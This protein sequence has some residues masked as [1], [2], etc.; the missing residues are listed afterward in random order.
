MRPNRK[1]WRS[2]RQSGDGREAAKLAQRALDAAPHFI[3]AIIFASG[4]ALALG[5]R[6]QAERM[7]SQAWSS[8]PHPALAQYFNEIHRDAD[9]L[10]R[11]KHFEKLTGRNPD[12]PES[13]L[14][15][16]SGALEAELWGSAR[17]QL[18]AALAAPPS[19][20]IYRRLAQLEEAGHDDKEA[21][22]RWLLQASVAPP[23]PLWV[24]AE[25]GAPGSE[26]SLACAACGALDGMDWRQPAA[27]PAALEARPRTAPAEAGGEAAD[28]A[29]A[30]DGPALSAP[31]GKAA[32]PARAG[33]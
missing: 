1:G 19:A 20:G 5:R 26:W 23:D 12:H 6:S 11:A 32:E 14:L 13:H 24:C 22:R 33:D 25:C 21:A 3:A 16:S 28:K 15:L 10:A 8:T 7:I 27:P 2:A 30:A 4:Q 29:D 9:R 18:E 17:T 31:E